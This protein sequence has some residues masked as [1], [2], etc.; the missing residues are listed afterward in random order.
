MD[1]YYAGILSMF[2]IYVCI[3]TE[4][5]SKVMELRELEIM[6]LTGISKLTSYILL[7][8][9]NHSIIFI[10]TNNKVLMKDG[11]IGCNIHNP[12]Y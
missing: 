12:D 11:K 8:L 6:Q 2:P 10:I 9:P 5:F 1:N 7:I 3:E 4:R